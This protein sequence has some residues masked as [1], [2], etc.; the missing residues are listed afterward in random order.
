MPVKARDRL[1]ATAEELFY[2]EGIR[3]VGIERILAESGVGRA[4]LYRH[5]PSKDDL[6][7]AVLEARDRRW[8]SWLAER[9]EALGGHP[10][11]VFDALAERFAH[12]DFRGCAFINTMIESADPDSPAHRVA[13]AH[14]ERVVDYLEQL[15]TAAEVT[16]P[17]LQARQ[18]ALLMDGAIVTALRERTPTPAARARRLAETLLTADDP[19]P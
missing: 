8:R 14:K 10:L 12:N 9:V 18:F 7:V 19:A 4:S 6:V 17:A 5:F 1:L 13:A 16:E 3:A 2:A 11:A 15:L